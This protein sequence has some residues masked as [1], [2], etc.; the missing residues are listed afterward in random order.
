MASDTR[1]R[2]LKRSKADLKQRTVDVRFFFIRRD[3]GAT[4]NRQRTPIHAMSIIEHRHCAAQRR[5][6]TKPDHPT[7]SCQRAPRCRLR[8]GMR[9]TSS[10][11]SL[12]IRRKLTPD[13]GIR[14]HRERSPQSTRPKRG[15]CD[16][17]PFPV[18]TSPQAFAIPRGPLP[19]THP[20]I[21][22]LHG[23]GA[24]RGRR[25]RKRVLGKISKNKNAGPI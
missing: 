13:G 14:R 22:L 2:Q 6:F 21:T 10:N 5:Q 25:G 7:G 15:S 18:V 3:L 11:C 20:P 1:S 24:H 16:G 19:T 8:S 4:G 9:P 23:R 17:S 12:P